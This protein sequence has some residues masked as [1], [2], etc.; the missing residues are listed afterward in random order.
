MTTS[1]MP[2]HHTC[3]PRETLSGY[4]PLEGGREVGRDRA[5]E[6]ERASEREIDPL[7]PHLY[8]H[9][10]PP[11]LP[12]E[13]EREREREGER[14]REREGGGERGRGSERASEREGESERARAREREGEGRRERERAACPSPTSVPPE[15]NC[16]VTSP[17]KDKLQVMNLKGELLED[18]QR[19]SSRLFPVPQM[20]KNERS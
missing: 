6:R 4:A 13:R 16:Q 9:A 19:G 7:S 5:R 3:A 18:I 8:I 1:V 11:H 15:S 20:K 12:R 17:E 14:E 2:S 10:L